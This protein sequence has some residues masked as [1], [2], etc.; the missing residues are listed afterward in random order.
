MASSAKL[1]KRLEYSPPAHAIGKV[2]LDFEIFEG[3]TVVT[4]T[5]D[6]S[7][8]GTPSAE[9][10]TSLRL[11]KG[12]HLQL[13]SVT[14]DGAAVTVTE[15]DGIVSVPVPAAD[16]KVVTRSTIFPEK[17]TELEG[18]YREN[19]AA[20]KNYMT[21][22]EAEGFREISPFID[23]PDNLSVYTVR[24]SAPLST[25][26]VLLSNGD[27][28][29]R[30]TLPE[31]RHFAVWNDPHPKPCYLFALVAGD[32]TAR[33]ATFT[34]R[35]GR[36]VACRVWTSAAELPRSGWALESLLRAM[37]WDEE[38]FGLEYDLDQFNIVSTPDFNMGAYAP[39]LLL[40]GM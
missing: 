31:G 16:C 5:L 29:E 40:A 6:V 7:V 23:R 12:K 18:L 1:I 39:H 22:C 8:R 17:N 15:S 28:T 35:S 2:N 33:E 14:V 13:D 19:S 32:L 21:Q 4:A 11:H 36:A 9:A 37:K 10:A 38:R 3:H 24:V 34:T 27:C 20:S 30:G 25:C 26:P